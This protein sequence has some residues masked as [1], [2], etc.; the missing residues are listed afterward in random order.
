MGT[1][2]APPKPPWTGSYER[3][4]PGDHGTDVDLGGATT[5]GGQIGQL[6]DDLDRTVDDV[7]TAIT[8][9]L[10]NRRGYLHE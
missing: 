5:A 7:D 4:R 1:S 3:L 2:G 9:G 10:S 8:P 6:I